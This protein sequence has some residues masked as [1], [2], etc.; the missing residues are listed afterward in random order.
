MARWR[1]RLKH[2]PY[3]VIF[4]C[5][6][7]PV[8]TV[9]YRM[10]RMEGGLEQCVAFV[11]SN[12]FINTLS[13]TVTESFLS[14]CLSIALAFPGA[15]FFS[16]FDFSGKRWWR[17]L[18]IL[19]FMMPG[20]II[21]LA[22]V[23][24]YGQ[25]GVFNQLLRQIS[26]G[27]WR[28]TGL[29]GFWGIVLAHVIYNLPL[30]LRMLG[31]SWER[32]DPRLEE[33]SANLGSSP[34]NTWRRLTWPLLLSTIG[35]L[36]VIVFLYSFLSFTVVLVFGGYLFKTFEV[37]IYIEYNS[38]LRFEQAS[39]IAGLQTL[40]LA[41]I[42]LIQGLLRQKVGYPSKNSR[43]PPRLGFKA[44][45]RQTTGFFMYNAGL[46]FFLAGPFVTVF[47][48]S[49]RGGGVAGGI[50]TL[51]NY[52]LLL[53]EA[54]RFSTGQ[55]LARVIGNSLFLSM[56]VAIITVGFAYFFARDRRS[57][58]WNLVDLGLQ[59]PLGI[60]FMSFG[61]GL[62]NLGGDHIP[63]W[64]LI[65]W[66]QVYLAFPLVYAILRTAWRNFDVTLLESARLLGAD[67]RFVFW[68]LEAPLLKKA[69]R[70]AF[71]YSLAIS[72]G[73]LA[74]VL[75]LGNGEVITL[76]VAI[77]RLIGHYRFAQATALGSLFIGISFLV[78]LAI[79][80]DRFH[81]LEKGESLR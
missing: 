17:S 53:S 76:S 28:F 56:T 69:V 49:L 71:A 13:F 80:A 12:L 46:L 1:F 61:F 19:P 51:S 81:L 5:F 60:S 7:L 38:K 30:C 75:L 37:L 22:M 66:A 78:F 44:Y 72:L 64:L 52:R 41:L 35:Y 39:M 6:Y 10:L 18:L 59:L 3:L 16:R 2:L 23:V 36:W 74:A 55:S 26:G 48:R 11:R 73:D 62:F 79:E 43:Q 54:F 20:I 57:Q 65:I 40:I 63:G 33:A 27:E 8:L 14:A 24:F 29:Y 70:T 15:Y 21:V 77:Y 42:F 4:S 31:D 67:S 45:P 9:F 50:L 58:P 25:N 32:L 47:E 68:T 34:W